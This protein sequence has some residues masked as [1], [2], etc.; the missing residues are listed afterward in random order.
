MLII[1]GLV[2]LAC[3]SIALVG[4]AVI[5]NQRKKKRDAD[6]ARTL[7]EQGMKNA[8]DAKLE[9]EMICAECDQSIDAAIDL[10]I[11]D[12]DRGAWWH[13]KCYKRVAG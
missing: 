10:Y 7:R 1:D 9:N 12:A 11:G 13:R 2:A 5:A 6:K 4:A 8:E 3:L